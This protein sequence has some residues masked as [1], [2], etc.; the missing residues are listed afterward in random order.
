M[1]IINV[2]HMMKAHYIKYKM[3]QIRNQIMIQCFKKLVYEN[4]PFSIR[5]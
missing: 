1:N 4:H 2:M 5:N 3:Y